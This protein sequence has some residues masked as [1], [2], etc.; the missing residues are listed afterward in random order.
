MVNVS[1]NGKFGTSMDYS[2]ILDL[3]RR[4]V[5]VQY[6]TLQNPQNIPAIKPVF[7]QSRFARGH[8][9]NPTTEFYFQRGLYNVFGR[10][11]K[12]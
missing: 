5:N 2:Q 1:S 12:M 7:G 8:D 4:A 10:I 11:G 9:T 6:M 3:K